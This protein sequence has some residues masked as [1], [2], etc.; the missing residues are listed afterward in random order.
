MLAGMPSSRAASRLVKPSR[1]VAR[2]T[3]G[4]PISA[5][6][7]TVAAW[8]RN[9]SRGAAYR[10]GPKQWPTSG[11]DAQ[12]AETVV[13][14]N[15]NASVA[16]RAALLVSFPRGG[17]NSCRSVN[18]PFGQPGSRHPHNRASHTSRTG[19]PKQ[20]TSA[21]TLRRRPWPTATTPHEGQPPT[22]ASDSMVSTN[23]SGRRSTVRTCIPGT[24]NR[25]SVRGHQGAR[26][27]HVE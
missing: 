14:S 23:R 16:H 3:A 18:T 6:T 15:V 22:S 20:G 4:T 24:S 2:T 8:V 13:S 5:D 11:H 12:I 26:E 7:R 9:G 21:T 1:T 25:V 27:A 19:P 17:T 10:H